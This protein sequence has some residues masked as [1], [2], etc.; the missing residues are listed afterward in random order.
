VSRENV[1]IVSRGFERL[2]ATGEL[3]EDSFAP[4]FVLDMSKFRGWPEQHVYEG[5]DGW[6]RF[7]RE[8]TESFDE[9]QIGVEAQHDA[10]EKVV[11][12]CRQHGRAKASGLP[13][14]M[15]FAMVITL[16]DGLQTRIEMYADPAEALQ[17]AALER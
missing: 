7:L 8:W 2:L 9:W 1:D 6:R 5:A 13:V 12:V 17:A 14:D 16:R 10:G 11:T 3:P 4:D 15:L